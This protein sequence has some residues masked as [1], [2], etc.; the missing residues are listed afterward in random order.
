MRVTGLKISQ[1]LWETNCFAREFWGE[2]VLLVHLL[3]CVV[4]QM[5]S[6]LFEKENGPLGNGALRLCSIP[7]IVGGLTSQAV[8]MLNTNVDS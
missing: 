2:S 3:S 4:H 8:S 7:S 6:V 1:F 5:I